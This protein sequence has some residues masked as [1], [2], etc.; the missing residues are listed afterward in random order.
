MKACTF[1]SIKRFN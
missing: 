1:E